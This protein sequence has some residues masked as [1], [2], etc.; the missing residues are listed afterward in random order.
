[1]LDQHIGHQACMAAVAIRER[2]NHHQPMVKANGDL[3][4]A[5]HLVLELVGDVAQE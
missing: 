1:M 5:A 3:I 4:V 2:V